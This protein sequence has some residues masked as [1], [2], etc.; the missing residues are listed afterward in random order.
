MDCF[1]ER[2]PFQAQQ[3][4]YAKSYE[5]NLF[6]ISVW[7]QEENQRKKKTRLRE[8]VLF[9][10]RLLRGLQAASRA[11]KIQGLTRNLEDF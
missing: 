3:V 5:K 2:L 11:H 6:H 4:K 8:L 10:R 1:Y 7:P 9:K